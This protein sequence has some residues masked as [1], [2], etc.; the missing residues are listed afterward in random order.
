ML[1]LKTKWFN[2]WAKM[3]F[4]TDNKLLK[5]LENISNNLGTVDLEGELYKVRTRN[6]DKGKVEDLELL[7]YLKKRILQYLFIDLLRLTKIIWIS[8][9]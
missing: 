4:I 3:N 1:K 6:M 8:K 2:K 5:T 9:N 7:L